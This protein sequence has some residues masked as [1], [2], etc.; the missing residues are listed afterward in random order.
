M[1]SNLFR[2]ALA[3]TVIAV[4]APATTATTAVAGPTGRDL[5]GGR[6]SFEGTTLNLAAGWGAARACAVTP[7]AT[8]CYRSE[9]AMD[10]ALAA[11][12]TVLSTTLEITPLATCGSSL[13][14]YDGTSFGG[15]VISF[16]TTGSLISL[17]TYGFDNK[18]SSYKV[19]ACAANLY[20]GLQTGLYPGNTAANAQ[21]A[22]MLSGWDNTISS[23]LMP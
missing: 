5:A 22:T 18:T 23:V 4:V 7:T 19:G 9:A 6:A 20:S 10:A 3:A 21:A 2:R 1:A 8:T 17:A 13:R 12:R 15:Q 14:L 16:T 11:T